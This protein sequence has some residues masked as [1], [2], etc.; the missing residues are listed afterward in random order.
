MRFVP[1]ISHGALNHAA[2]LSVLSA[3]GSV[4]LCEG[5]ASPVNEFRDRIFSGGVVWQ[6]G[7]AR[8]DGQ[9]GLGVT[10]DERAIEE[11]TALRPVGTSARR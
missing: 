9:P 4:D 8:L 10:V 3:I 11:L 2:T 1:H 5:D 6:D 7:Q